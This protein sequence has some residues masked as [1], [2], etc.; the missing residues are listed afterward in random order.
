MRFVWQGK[1]MGLNSIVSSP[2][3]VL[4]PQQALRLANVYLE[5]ACNVDDIDIVLVLC[6]DAE[7]SLSQAKKAIK[8]AEDQY[9]IG[10]IAVAYMDL[11]SVLES[12]GHP[13]EAKASYKKA[14]KL[15]SVHNLPL[16]KLMQRR[17][18]ATIPAHIFAKDIRP[19]VIEYTLP[20]SD[21]RLSN[22]PQ[23][24]YC[25]YLLNA[26][27]SHDDIPDQ[28][29]HKW[30]DAIEKD[31]DEQDR[32]KSMAT[33]VIKAFKRDEL[34]DAKTVAEVVYLTPVLDK[35]SFQSLLSL[36][37]SG[38][39][40]S[41]LLKIHQLEGLAQSIQNA[42]HGHLSPDDLRFSEVD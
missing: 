5:N 26:H 17:G 28:A 16:D 40:H 35:E 32:L 2:R 13:N 41:G 11:G 38:I 31:M 34:K 9:I 23:L 14:A 30:L 24:A 37:Y 10:E 18:S 15:G 3:G 20:G 8:R 36:F 4:S 21:E 12:Q 19:P 33:E 25:L 22:T 7:V 29:T 39:D 42:D 6:Q 1:N 27:T